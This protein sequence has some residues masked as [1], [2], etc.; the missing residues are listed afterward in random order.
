MPKLLENK[1]QKKYKLKKLEKKLKKR[2]IL[3]NRS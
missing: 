2:E 1:F 3:K